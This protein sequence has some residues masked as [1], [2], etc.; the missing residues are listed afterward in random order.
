MRDMLRAG[1]VVDM[2][3]AVVV[4]AVALVTLRWVGHGP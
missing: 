4:V 3:A 1:W 2:L